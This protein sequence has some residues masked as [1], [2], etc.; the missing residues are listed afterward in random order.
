MKLL[1]RTTTEK[2]VAALDSKRQSAA[3]ICGLV[4]ANYVAIVRGNSLIRVAVVVLSPSGAACCAQCKQ[5]KQVHRNT[6]AMPPTTCDLTGSKPPY[7]RGRLKEPC[8]T[9]LLWQHTQ[10]KGTERSSSC[11][12]R[13]GLNDLVRSTLVH[14]NPL[15]PL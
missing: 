14:F 15:I 11:T 10:H 13:F 6:T 7:C 9:I 3:D 5:P 2:T 1:A 8:K 4:C 12:R